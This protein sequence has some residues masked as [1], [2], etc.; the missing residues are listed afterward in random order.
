[1][2]LPPT[3]EPVVADAA[4][5]AIWPVA[6]EGATVLTSEDALLALI[7]QLS[8]QPGMVDAISSL[9]LLDIAVSSAPLVALTS[10]SLCVG[11]AELVVRF[12]TPI[13]ELDPLACLFAPDQA[14]ART[15]V[16]G[17]LYGPSVNAELIPLIAGLSPISLVLGADSI[18]FVDAE[19]AQ[20]R[21]VG[22]HLLSGQL[23]PLVA[24]LAASVRQLRLIGRGDFG[25][26]TVIAA[27]R[28]GGSGGGEA[29]RTVTVE[30]A[31]GHWSAAKTRSIVRLL[32]LAC[33]R[34]G[35]ALIVQA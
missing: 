25:P 34:R 32:E 29:F 33:T 3:P 6:D 20:V 12:A 27:L 5:R 23:G 4:E 14:A 15:L 28:G 26:A 13:H 24:A 1:M 35:I 2:S 16:I 8:E 11:L 19:G 9:H 18:S 7:D 10:T 22:D 21:L 17:P 31:S 30:D